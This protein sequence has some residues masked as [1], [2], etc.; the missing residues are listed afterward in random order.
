MLFNHGFVFCSKAKPTPESIS[1]CWRSCNCHH[2]STRS[3]DC[4]I[5]WGW[6][7]IPLPGPAFTPLLPPEEGGKWGIF[8]HSFSSLHIIIASDFFVLMAG[9]SAYWRGG[10]WQDFVR[11]L[12]GQTRRISYWCS[13]VWNRGDTLMVATAPWHLGGGARRVEALLSY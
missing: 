7:Q 1:L 10:G 2:E 11:C 3:E 9:L 4:E 13:S 5:D 6:P 8:P 12:C